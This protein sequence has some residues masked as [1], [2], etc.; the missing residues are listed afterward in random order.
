MEA[1]VQ[2]AKI[3]LSRLIEAVLLG[4]E[5]T[6][7]RSGRPVA[8]LV[9]VEPRC[10]RRELGSAKGQFTVPDDFNDPLDPET[11]APFWK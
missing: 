2:E 9:P 6:I 10:A 4:E 5:V 3:H 1:S 8:R 7:T 11:A